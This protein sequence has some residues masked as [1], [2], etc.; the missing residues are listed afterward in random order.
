MVCLNRGRGS[1]SE[2]DPSYN[3]ANRQEIIFHKRD[4]KP[5]VVKNPA[6]LDGGARA[7][8]VT[9]TTEVRSS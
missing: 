6:I 1:R 3:T 8:S 7:H 9:P 5:H 4:A 2:P